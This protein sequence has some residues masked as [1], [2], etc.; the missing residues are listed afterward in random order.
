L[1]VPELA[2][3]AGVAALIFGPSKLPELGKAAGET[4]KS[5]QMAAKEFNEELK[6]GMDVRVPCL[7]Q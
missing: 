7:T 2:V 4:A 5:F 3:I 6:K 1:G